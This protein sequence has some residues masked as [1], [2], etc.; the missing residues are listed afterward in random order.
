MWTRPGI[1][2]NTHSASQTMLSDGQY[3][4]QS[5]LSSSKQDRYG[6]LSVLA[7]NGIRTGM[8]RDI[9]YLPHPGQMRGDRLGHKAVPFELGC[10]VR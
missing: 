8:S 3:L 4:G 10:E 2:N 7:C 1:Q 6:D 5:P 9:A